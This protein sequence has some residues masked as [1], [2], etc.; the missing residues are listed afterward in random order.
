MTTGVLY[1]LLCVVLM[2][3]AEAHNEMLDRWMSELECPVIL[4]A[5]T[6]KAVSRPAFTVKDGSGRIRTFE[7]CGNGFFVDCSDMTSAFTDSRT[8]GDTLKACD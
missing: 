3:C 5:K 6:D 2:G 7:K 8:I 4:I 1:A